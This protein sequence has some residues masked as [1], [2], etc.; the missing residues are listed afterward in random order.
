VDLRLQDKTALVTGGSNGIGKGIARGLAQEGCHVAMCARRPALLE[1][2]AAELRQA[3]G[4]QL[5][6]IPADLTQ[7]ADAERFVH[8]AASALGRI[9]I[10]V[11]NAGAAPG[12]PLDFLTEEHWAA[13]LQLKFPHSPGLSGRLMSLRW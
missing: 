5:L 13:A 1:A 8:T 4:R 9:D 10:L 2:T 12:G 7:P 6:A 11:N 3:T